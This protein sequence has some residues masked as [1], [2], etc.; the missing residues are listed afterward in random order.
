MLTTFENVME[1]IDVCREQLPIE[2]RENKLGALVIATLLAI[3]YSKTLTYLLKG[4]S[5]I[6][7]LAYM[8]REFKCRKKKP[9]NKSKNNADY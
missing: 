9:K 5:A 8:I 3:G 7:V 2:M 4:G 6:F 1:G